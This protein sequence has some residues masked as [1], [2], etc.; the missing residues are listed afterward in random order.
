MVD[1]DVQ[2]AAKY[3][4]EKIFRLIILLLLGVLLT[5]IHIS[6]DCFAIQKDLRY[7]A[8]VAT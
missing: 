3:F 1:I 4:D 7:Y 6:K 2:N 8:K 5:L